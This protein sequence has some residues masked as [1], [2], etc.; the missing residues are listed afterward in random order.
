MKMRV[1]LDKAFVAHE[2]AKA[3]LSELL[4]A[5]LVVLYTIKLVEQI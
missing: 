3:H 1:C 4:S 5:V 2:D